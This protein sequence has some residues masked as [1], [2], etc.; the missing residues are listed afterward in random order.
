MILEENPNAIINSRLAGYGDYSTPENGPPVFRPDAPCWEL[1]L[2]MNDSWGYQPRDTNYKS[3]NQIIA[4]LA[5]CIYYGGNLLLDIGPREDGSIPEEQLAILGEMGRWTHKHSE[6]VYGTLPGIPSECYYGPSCIS[7]DSTELY[8]FLN[9]KPNGALALKGLKS[10]VKKAEVL[11][12]GKE[13]PF[14][15]MMKPSWSS[16]PG[17]L[18]LEIPA[19]LLDPQM[20]VIKLTLEGKIRISP[21]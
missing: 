5:D 11:G 21:K 20:T 16:Y 6:A 17:I 2:T 9:G 7:K 4:I 19:D 8:L 18:Y 10:K 13:I 14:K 1:C 12:T 15:L 3:A